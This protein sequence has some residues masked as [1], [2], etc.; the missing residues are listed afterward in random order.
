LMSERCYYCPNGQN[1]PSGNTASYCC[2]LTCATCSQYASVCYT[3]IAFTYLSNGKCLSCPLNQINP[4]GNSNSFC[5]ICLPP[6][7]SCVRDDP[8][9]C[10]S[11]PTN[12]YVNLGTC[13]ACPNG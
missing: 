12:H 13:S 7:I 4:D 5:S 6:C 11:C 9:I 2:P 3:C 10:Y 8:T 1:N